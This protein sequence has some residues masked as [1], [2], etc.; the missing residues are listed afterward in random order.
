M[1]PSHIYQLTTASTISQLA[2]SIEKGWVPDENIL[3]KA[4]MTAPARLVTKPAEAKSDNVS[5]ISENVLWTGWP[6]YQQQNLS[7][8]SK[9]RVSP[10]IQSSC[11]PISFQCARSHE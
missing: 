6:S 7:A 10:V 9:N 11:L 4:G 1:Q 8:I 3:T 5:S 2:T